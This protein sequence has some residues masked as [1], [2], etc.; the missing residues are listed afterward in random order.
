[1]GRPYFRKEVARNHNILSSAEL[2]VIERKKLRLTCHI[3]FVIS[4][5]DWHS[6]GLSGPPASIDTCQLAFSSRESCD[7]ARCFWLQS[8]FE[9]SLQPRLG[10]A[11]AIEGERL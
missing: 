10:S 7:K 3:R 2:Y 1:M 11:I 9:L 8:T 5:N 6:P 4:P